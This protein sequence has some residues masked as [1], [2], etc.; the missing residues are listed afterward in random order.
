MLFRHRAAQQL[1]GI[2]LTRPLSQARPHAF[3]RNAPRYT[4]E[5]A[6]RQIQS[7]TLAHLNAALSV[8]V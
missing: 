1:G 5:E 3:T 7:H 4:G 2:P 8:A 6:H